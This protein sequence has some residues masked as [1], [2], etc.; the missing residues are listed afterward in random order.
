MN[1][2]FQ[3]PPG[4]KYSIDDLLHEYIYYNE[5]HL[6]WYVVY[7][8]KKSTLEIVGVSDSVK[9]ELIDPSVA[10]YCDGN[11][12]R[13][14]FQPDTYQS[15]ANQLDTFRKLEEEAENERIV[16]FE[17]YGAV[18]NIT[19]DTFEY[20]VDFGNKIPNETSV[21]EQGVVYRRQF[22]LTNSSTII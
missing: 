4:A 15:L 9:L 19:E 18:S 13:A 7:T 21:L 14:K 22:S 20:Y 3:Y 5:C 2:P 8:V 1:P 12:K 6:N 16:S 11:Y 10:E 17:A